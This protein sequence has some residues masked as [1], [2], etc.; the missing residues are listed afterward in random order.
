MKQHEAVLEAMRQNG[1]YATLGHLYRTVLKI[2]GCHWGTKTPFASIRRIVQIY[3]NLFFKI[4]PGLWALTSEREAVLEKL[5]SGAGAEVFNHSYYQ[6]LIVEIGNLKNYE[7][8]VPYQD[9]N[10]LF[11]S[12]KLAE[13]ST[14]REFHNFTY[15]SLL[16]RAKTVDVSWFNQR[17]LPKA[18]FE[19]EHSTGM[20]NS[21]LKFLDFEDFRINFFIVA[22]SAR[23]REFESKIASAT[24]S[25]IRH[26]IKFLDYDTLADTHSKISASLP[27][28]KLLGL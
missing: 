5:A 16:R 20:H 19:V 25:P 3:P 4:K 17:R 7:T 22:D 8:F 21:L 13:V 23:K 2:P 1:G 6:G 27:A 14:L 28:E 26:A 18:F 15:D 11:L 12:R 10:K 9:K 24:F